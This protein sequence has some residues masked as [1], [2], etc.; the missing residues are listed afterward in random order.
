MRCS[1]EGGQGIP[2]H[3]GCFLPIVY[4]M[5]GLCRGDG[6]HGRSDL[7]LLIRAPPP[8]LQR[9]SVIPAYLLALP[10]SIFCALLMASSKMP[11]KEFCLSKVLDELELGIPEVATI[12]INSFQFVDL[13]ILLGCDYCDT[14]RGIFSSHPSPLTSLN[15]HF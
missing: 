1:C 10:S 9:G 5:E 3:T 14:I 11:I 13:C 12:F 7:W 4:L 2:H 15:A 8:Y 6:G